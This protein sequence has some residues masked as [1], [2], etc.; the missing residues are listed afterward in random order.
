[1]ESLVSIFEQAPVLSGV[2]YIVT[3][4]IKRIWEKNVGNI[5]NRLMPLVTTG[6]GVG[7]GFL[8]VVANPLLGAVIGAASGAIHDVISPRP[9]G[10]K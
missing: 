9:D 3:E 1:M 10:P 8:P 5:P 4:V 7:I 6:L 2:I